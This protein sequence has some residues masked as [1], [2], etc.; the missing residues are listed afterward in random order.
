MTNA[1]EWI[2]FQEAVGL[3]SVKA[4]RVIRELGSPRRML[5]LSPRALFEQG[6]FV[7]REAEA[8][9]KKPWD[10]AKRTLDQAMKLGYTVLTPDHP[11]YPINLT[12]ID[13]MPCVLYVQDSTASDDLSVLSKGLILAMVGTRKA[14]EYGIQAAR[15]LSLDLAAA[16]CTI[17][18]G[19][20]VGIDSVCHE[21]ALK[22][23]GG[24]VGFMAC[25]LDVD[26][27]K[28]SAELKR[29]ILASGG[30]L[31]SEY[32]PGVRAMPG[33]F[34]VRNRLISG[35][36]E[37]VVVLEAGEN[38]GALITA[39]HAM[40]QNRDVFAV[41]GGIFDRNL[42]GCNRLIRDGAK[43]VLNAYSILEEYLTHLP[44]GMTPS[45]IVA[46]IKGV[47]RLGAPEAP[48][49]QGRRSGV[50][51]AGPA[52]AAVPARVEKLS[53]ERLQTMGV[54]ENA[55]RVYISLE[56][57]PAPGEVIAARSGLPVMSV[58]ASMTE[59]ELL[60]LA[61]LYPGQRYSL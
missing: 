27:P 56:R 22:A 35:I 29:R 45:K 23:G 16:G 38:S 2:W 49:R 5:E 19:L 30:A 41:P 21:G 4:D 9:L 53:Q 15:N 7:E 31:V 1:L 6:F 48:K 51:S 12:H 60:G 36:A 13:A 20:A 24:T 43:I 3:G 52:K 14:S 34:H 32:P 18:S 25:G 10:N 58:M 57:E 17:V 50:V 11:N 39:H 8:I 54:T 42:V 47:P 55:R 59:L 61:K 40:E 44:E 46:A 37:G 26:Y 28:E 33:H